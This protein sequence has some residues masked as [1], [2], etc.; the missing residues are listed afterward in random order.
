M[1]LV[2]VFST[3]V[4]IM[5]LLSSSYA[6]DYALWELPEGAKFRLGKGKISDVE[7]RSSFQFS[8]D[9]KEFL[10]FTSIGI[11]V[12]DAYTGKELRLL[13]C[14]MEADQNRIVISPDGQIVASPTDKWDDPV[15]Q[16]WDFKT[17]QLQTTLQGH[18]KR[19][20][21]LDFSGNSKMLVSGDF[22][23]V[24]KI[25]NISTGQ[26]RHIQTP[27]SIVSRLQFSPNGQTILSSRNGNFK[28][29]D[30]DTGAINS[31][32]N[33]TDRI[34]KIDYSPDGELLFGTNEWWIRLWDAKT[35]SVKMTFKVPA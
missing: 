5:I 9:G 13:T 4:L 28:L 17:G 3:M 12:Y 27:H 33:G 34:R 32:L 7:R 11:W 22:D 8:P 14:S 16:L 6:D 23:G 26:H 21:S 29:W 15:I 2:R 25:W 30:V 20:T 19:I 31:D 35:G 1:R 18:T 24:M 10:V